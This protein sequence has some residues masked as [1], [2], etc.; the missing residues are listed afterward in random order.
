METINIGIITILYFFHIG[1]IWKLIVR[2]LF[3][4]CTNYQ[5]FLYSI[6]KIEIIDV[7]NY[8]AAFRL[9]FYDFNNSFTC[10]LEGIQ[11]NSISITT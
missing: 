1:I 2:V 3:F 5:R 4:S 7:F 9:D 6:V 11:V 10:L 8:V